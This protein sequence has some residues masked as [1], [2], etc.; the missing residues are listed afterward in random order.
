MP[1]QVQP[2]SQ[3]VLGPANTNGDVLHVINNAGQIVSWEDRNS[4]TNGIGGVTTAYNGPAAN[5]AIGGAGAAFVVANAA[6][7]QLAVNLPG[8]GAYD[9]VPFI[10]HP[11]G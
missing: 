7:T 6:G 11:A 2:S 9:C 5:L 3:I 1:Q 4:L 8:N 10:V